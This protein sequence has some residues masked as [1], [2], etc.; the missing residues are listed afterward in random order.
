MKKNLII[1]LI[2]FFICGCF[3][4]CAKKVIKPKN[5]GLKQS[6]EVI[7]KKQVIED[8]YPLISDRSLKYK[9]F[10]NEYAGMTSYVDYIR[11]NKIQIRNINGGTNVGQVLEIKNGELRL[12]LSL[13]EFYYRTDLTGIE[14]TKPEILLKEPLKIG[15]SWKL[16]NGDSRFI[17]GLDKSI[18]TPLGKYKALEVTTKNKESE[19]RDYYVIQTG[20][21]KSVF[22]TKG[23]QIT[24]ELEKLNKKAL[25]TQTL[26]IYY[27]DI[28]KNSSIYVEHTINLKTNEDIKGY[29]EKYFREK[30]SSNSLSLF[31]QKAKINMLAFER[32]KNLVKVDFSKE[33]ADEMNSGASK[34][35]L[36]LKAVTNTLGNYFNVDKVYITIDGKP[37]SSKNIHKKVDEPF[38]VDYKNTESYKGGV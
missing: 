18:E 4:G 13:G 12:L 35:T 31:G 5:I 23:G 33:F 2:T 15:T 16:P 21:V 25:V 34:E 36:V 29:I 19:Q 37:Y 28:K 27:P 26:K 1:I 30:P 6:Q 17:S 32:V 14:N 20:Y 22:I 10:G 3:L 11:N 9:G 24:S 8:Y 38:Y 7:S